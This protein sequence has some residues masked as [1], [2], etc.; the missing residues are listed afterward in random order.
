MARL[1]AVLLPLSLD[2]FALAA[3]LGVAGLPR[4]HRLRLTLLFA[5]FETGMPL[6]GMVF[7]RAAGAP[8]GSAGDGVAGA[9]L[10]LVG[11]YLIFAGD[12]DDAEVARLARARG[13]A[14]VALAVSISLDEL[15]IGL[16]AGLLRLP[17]MWTA[18]LMGCQAFLAAQLGLRFGIRLGERARE[19]AEAAA[20]LAL[21]ALGGLLLLDWLRM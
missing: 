17:L 3:A 5:G 12:D 7:G 21:V 15:A 6:L 20:G 1:I 11:G 8:L 4:S 10:I 2:T 18:L 13:F 16:G 19:R 14:L 9:V